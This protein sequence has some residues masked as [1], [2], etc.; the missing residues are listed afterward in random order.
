MTR[1]LFTIPNFLTAGSGRAMLNVIERLDR[2]QFEPHV[3]VAR[4]GGDLCRE[5]ERQGIPVMEAPFTVA[6]R[7]ALSLPGRVL[8]AARTFRPYRF[9]LWHSFHYLDDYTEPLVAKAAGAKA[10]IYTKK[11]MNWWRRSWRIRTWL[12]SG[13]AAQN[14]S[15]L[16]DFFPSAGTRRKT[17]LIPP[18]VDHCRYH[19]ATE[20]RLRLR[21][22]LGI[23]QDE[24]VAALVAHIV[25]VKGHDT[26]LRAA[27]LVPGLRVWLAGRPQDREYT[28]SL[29]RL[30]GDLG[31]SERVHF[32]GAIGDIPALLAEVDIFVLSSASKGEGCPVALLEAMS[33]GVASIATDVPGCND[34][35]QSGENGLLT[36]AGDPAA[37]ASRLRDLAG[38]RES[39][40]RLGAA[41]RRRIES[42]YTMAREVSSYQELYRRVL[43][44]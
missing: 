42:N 22:S 17:M 14:S 3:C 16:R 11:N 18:G 36:P 21:E 12:A 41:A 40:E 2:S 9:D 39:R 43:A 35:I 37:L 34:V 15:M 28:E 13:V 20:A 33:A 7:P 4:A 19:P 29:E 8:R 1:I 44:A 23:P 38:S 6:P 30:A 25:P 10:W 27:A 24:V 26:F 31:I 5:V 32:L